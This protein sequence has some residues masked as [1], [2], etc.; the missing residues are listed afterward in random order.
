ME[1]CQM[2]VLIFWKDQ[3]QPLAAELKLIEEARV[4][5]NPQ[6]CKFRKSKIIFLGY[7][8]DEMKSPTN[9]SDDFWALQTN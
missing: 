3:A 1:F 2:D 5:L 7:V 4:T 9:V 8:I 6:K